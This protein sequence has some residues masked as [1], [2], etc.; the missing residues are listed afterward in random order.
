MKPLVFLSALILIG[1]ASFGQTP[2]TVVNCWI[3]NGKVNY[4]HL[5]ELLPD[6]AKSGLLVDLRKEFNFRDGNIILLWLEQH[7]WKLTGID[8]E[9][10]SA[11]GNIS[12]ASTYIL[13][14]EIYLD[15]TARA[16]F[17]QRLEGIEKAK[18]Q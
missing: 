17:L 18:H 6:S 1:L 9:G 7:G 14:K 15:D 2:K 3:S 5:A 12:T 4:G 16:I 13:A 10:M 8:V 11:N